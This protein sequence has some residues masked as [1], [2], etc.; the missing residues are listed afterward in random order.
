[1]DLLIS[2]TTSYNTKDSK[3]ETLPNIHM[4]LKPTA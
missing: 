2:L 4:L 1:M 3:A